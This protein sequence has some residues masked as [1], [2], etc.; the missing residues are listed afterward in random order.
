MQRRTLLRATAA[1]LGSPLLGGACSTAGGGGGSSDPSAEP[2]EPAQ[3]TPMLGLHR[4][5]PSAVTIASIEVLRPAGFSAPSLWRDELWLRVRSSDGAVGFIQGNNRLP[6]LLPLL[7]NLV[8]PVFIGRDARDLESLVDEVFADERNYKF[9]GMP[10]WNC[11]GNLEIALW[12]LLSRVA[13]RPVS[14]LLEPAFGR[15][16]RDAIP[17]YVTRFARDTTPAQEIEAVQAALADSGARAVK[18]KIGGRMRAETM[19]GRSRA[20]IEGLRKALGDG[21]TINADANGSYGAH[22]AIEI[23]RMLEDHG[24]AVFEEPVSWQEYE[25]TGRVTAALQRIRVAGGEQDTALPQ[26]RRMLQGRVVDI[27]QP[28]PFYAGGLVRCLRIARLAQAAG[29]RIDCHNPKRGAS[30]APFQHFCA[31]VPNI[32]THQEYFHRLGSG[33]VRDG[34]VRIPTVP[35]LGREHREADWAGATRL[36]LVTR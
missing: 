19:P 26:F 21:I 12:D 1:A 33:E 22:E 4:A 28:D 5:L 23:G 24:V 35:G 6:L 16:V 7:E 25:A 13:Q 11:V 29:A 17:V 9:A 31:V 15:R 27:V 14:H 32:S 10:F 34:V 8:A 30:A 36:V 3:F 2:A 18:V 20:L